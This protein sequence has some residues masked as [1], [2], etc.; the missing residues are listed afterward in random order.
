MSINEWWITYHL[1]VMMGHAPYAAGHAPYAEAKVFTIML[2]Q[3][4]IFNFYYHHEICNK[5]FE[6]FR[7]ISWP[8]L[9]RIRLISYFH[10]VISPIIKTV[11]W[12]IIN[13][14]IRITNLARTRWGDTHLMQIWFTRYKITLKC[15]NLDE[16]LSKLEF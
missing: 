15:E 13:Y 1:Q 7:E 16:K 9:I 3:A 14:L 12:F 10:L 5:I 2:E 6:L 11:V 4:M 8:N